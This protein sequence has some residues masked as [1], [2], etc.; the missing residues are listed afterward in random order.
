MTAQKKYGI[1]LYKKGQC[2]GIVKD[3]GIKS[4]RQANATAAQW[5]KSHGY[6]YDYRAVIFRTNSA[7]F[8]RVSQKCPLVVECC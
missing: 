7:C 1:A 3:S 6:K 4:W 2:E 8:V 5:R